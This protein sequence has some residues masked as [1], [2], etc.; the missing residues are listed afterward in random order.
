MTEFEGQSV[1]VLGLGVSGVSATRFLV[2][3]GARVT[4]ADERA[5]DAIAGME[6]LPAAAELRVGDVPDLL[7][8]YK[9]LVSAVEALLVKGQQQQAPRS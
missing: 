9:L 1:L 5:P 4:A 7:S 8:E 6:D 2:E 3:R